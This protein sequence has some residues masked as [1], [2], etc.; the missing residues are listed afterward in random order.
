MLKPFI[1]IF[2]VLLLFTSCSSDDGSGGTNTPY[3][4]GA[5][6]VNWADNIIIPCY[7][8]FAV[9]TE[10]LEEKTLAFTANPNETNLIELRESFI[11]SY[12]EFQT[13]S[14]F[15]ISVAEGL[16]YRERLNTYPASVSE[17][18]Q[19]IS[20]NQYNLE[21]PSSFDEQGF[22][23]LDFLLFG[24]AETNAE[25]LAFYTTHPDAEAYKAYLNSLSESIHT[26]TNQVLTAWQGNFRDT[27][28]NNTSSSSTG[29]V[30]RLANDYV[31]YYE[32]YIR[33]G[34]IGI[35]A[36]IF[37]GNPV[38]GNTEAYYS[39]NISKT[40]YL[41]SLET[42]QN[43]FNGKHFNSTQTGLSFKQYLEFLNVTKNGQELETLIDTQFIVIKNQA[44][45]LND[46]FVTQIENNNILMLEAFDELQKNVVL[47]KVDMMQAL[48]ISIDYVD[49]D[50]D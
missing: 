44:D 39:G 11:E 47:L 48:S 25:T 22:P 49:S 19:R 7:E 50:G 46:N 35:P 33:T 21:L 24:L 37:T 14:L 26:L 34:K 5:M 31:L 12:I 4:R 10:T 42:V 13:V 28:V 2:S 16:N 6:L 45:G 15:E 18:E 30:D 32:R 43:F 41:K 20:A 36:G 40:L 17:I 9:F 23:A 1:S 29:S 27:F 8:N 3:D 38:P